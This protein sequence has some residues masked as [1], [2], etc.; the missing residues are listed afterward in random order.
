[1]LANQIP[2]TYVLAYLYTRTDCH[3]SSWKINQTWYVIHFGYHHNLYL[4]PLSRST[5]PNDL[6]R[7]RIAIQFLNRRYQSI[8]N[9]LQIAI[10]SKYVDLDSSIWN[11]DLEIVDLDS[12]W[13]SSIWNVDLHSSI[14]NSGSRRLCVVHTRYAFD[15]SVLHIVIHFSNGPVRLLGQSESGIFW[16]DITS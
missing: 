1:M 9:R 11:V 16:I 15:L 7:L 3:A 6:N 8:C 4:D 14:W 12:I 5:L 10:R 2:K 13:K